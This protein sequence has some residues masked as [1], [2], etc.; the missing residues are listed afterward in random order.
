MRDLPEHIY[1]EDDD[2]EGEKYPEPKEQSAEEMIK[3]MQ[4]Y[5]LI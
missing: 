1:D 3:V 5:N 2:E 4:Q